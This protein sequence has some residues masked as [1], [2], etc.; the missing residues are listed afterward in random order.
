MDS[1]I[2]RLKYP[3]PVTQAPFSVVDPHSQSPPVMLNSYQSPP[4]TRT[5]E[6]QITPMGSTLSRLCSIGSTET[7]TA[8]YDPSAASSPRTQFRSSGRGGAGN[9]RP[10]PVLDMDK[11]AYISDGHD[12]IPLTRLG[13][14]E[15]PSRPTGTREV[16]STG[17]GGAGNMRACHVEDPQP[18]P[19]ATLVGYDSDSLLVRGVTRESLPRSTRRGG[20]GN[21]GSPNS[22]ILVSVSV[23]T[24]C[25]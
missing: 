7:L 25:D 11:R 22:G 19:E 6:N 17:R 13:G 14:R 23:L 3:H 21:I 9:F 16:I 15:C 18:L 10:A 24:L 8:Q 1:L 20:A 12:D 4:S 5:L 2:C